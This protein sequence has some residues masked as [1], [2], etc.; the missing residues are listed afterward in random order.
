MGNQL[1]QLNLIAKQLKDLWPL[2]TFLLAI[3]TA[4]IGLLT[5]MTGFLVSQWKK[6][7]IA[8]EL[9]ETQ[10]LL[11]YTDEELARATECFIEP[12]CQATDPTGSEDFRSVVSPRE[13]VFKHLDNQISRGTEEKY[14]MI[15]ADSGMG[16]T[17]VLLNYLARHLRKQKSSSPA[18]RLI[19]LGV[20][21]ALAAVDKVKDQRNTI[22][23]LDALDEDTLAVNDHR[24]RLGEI[25]ERTS[26]FHHIVITC[27]TQFFAKDDEIPKETGQLRI[28]ATR[29]GQSKE[30]TFVKL[31]LSPFNDKQVEQYLARRFPIPFSPSRRRARLIAKQASD[32][33]MRPML[34]AHIREILSSG[35]FDGTTDEIYSSMINAWI[36]REKHFVQ[37]ND[38]VRFSK[39]IALDIYVNRVERGFERVPMNLAEQI[40][41][42]IGLALQPR[43]LRGRS[44]LNRDAEGNLKFAHRSI[45]EYLFIQ[46][47]LDN[48]ASTNFVRWTD[49]MKRFWWDHIYNQYRQKEMGGV[50][51]GMNSSVRSALKDGRLRGDTEGIWLIATRPLLTLEPNPTAHANERA[52]Q[53]HILASASMNQSHKKWLKS[54]PGFF[55][56]VPNPFWI[57]ADGEQECVLDLATGLLWQTRCEKSIHYSTA[58]EIAKRH[59]ESGALW[60]V[61]TLQE[62]LSLLPEHMSDHVDY[63][64]RY[65][66]NLFEHWEDIIW[67]RDTLGKSRHIA[68]QLHGYHL[69]SFP[70]KA[71]LRLV[72]SAQFWRLEGMRSWVLS[73]KFAKVH[74]EAIIRKED[75]DVD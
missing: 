10:S 15:L 74:A 41:S 30:Y 20:R 22:L 35:G 51:H 62:A 32:L 49:Q 24:A 36:E 67:T 23:L 19:P 12:D 44:L 55:Q 75:V 47:F 52:L 38:L 48:P 68:C 3:S 7:S 26:R 40:A 33:T 72:S 63:R 70:E 50:F 13:P 66:F 25:L 1:D 60:R 53:D 69:A 58:A 45:M 8:K 37:P 4:I 28:V 39:E 2:L 42:K 46:K 64:E 65:P 56:I 11:F 14:T 27:R 73:G 17:T 9:R 57:T 34:L 31:Y 54:F 18:L 6:Y 71:G 43:Q 21:D 16:K 5:K 61:P 29:A 59:R